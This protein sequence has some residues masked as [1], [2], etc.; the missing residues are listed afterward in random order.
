VVDKWLEEKYPE[1]FATVREEFA[2]KVADI[3]QQI[4]ALSVKTAA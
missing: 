4:A 2:Q 3:D 1:R